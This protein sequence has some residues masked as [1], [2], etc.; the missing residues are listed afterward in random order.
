LQ[1]LE[2][3]LFKAMHWKS[4]RLDWTYQQIGKFTGRARDTIARSLEALER[5]GILERMRR[6][7]VTEVDGK[8]PQV[9]QAA[10]AY[11]VKLPARLASLLGIR[12]P[13]VPDDHEI[14]A[15]DGRLSNDLYLSEI[16]GKPTLGSALAKLRIGVDQRESRK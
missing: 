16:T 14:A 2:C 12:A 1:I 10:N 11:R 8:G 7:T 4:G 15:R 6:F 13:V 9:H 5:V 3:L